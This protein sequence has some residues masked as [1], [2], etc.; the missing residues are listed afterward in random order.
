MNALVKILGCLITIVV[1]LKVTM[2]LEH[3]LVGMRGAPWF[4]FYAFEMVLVWGLVTLTCV[5]VLIQSVSDRVG[6]FIGNWIRGG[7]FWEIWGKKNIP[8]NTWIVIAL[9]LLWSAITYGP[10]TPS[11]DW[12]KEKYQVEESFH[13]AIS[14][15]GTQGVISG[16]RGAINYLSRGFLGI[17][18]IGQSDKESEELAPLL[19]LYE[20]GWWRIWVALLAVPFAPL[21]WA[22]T[23]RDELV[24][25]ISAIVDKFREKRETSGSAT[26]SPAGSGGILK[27]IVGTSNVDRI[28][29]HAIGELLAR[30]G[31]SVFGFLSKLMKK[32]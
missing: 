21:V 23:R 26:S 4:N 25:K 28:A 29:D 11:V 17:E 10:P 19:P 7:G 16:A 1:G 30:G 13:K 3:F 2:V 6:L 14:Q 5:C 9:V 32:Y 12:G 15:P 18:V 27:T 20:K 8:G 22:W 24:G 31:E